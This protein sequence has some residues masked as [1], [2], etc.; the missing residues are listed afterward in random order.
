M[1][2]FQ[3]PKHVMNTIHGKFCRLLDSDKA[4][5]IRAKIEQKR[6]EAKR[7]FAKK[8]RNCTKK[9]TRVQLCEE[10]R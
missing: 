3:G 8:E 6:L 1:Q 7:R 9:K 5:V 4:T 10:F 2:Q